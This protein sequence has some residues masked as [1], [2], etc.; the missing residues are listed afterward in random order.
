M[1]KKQNPEQQRTANP[2]APIISKEKIFTEKPQ[3]ISPENSHEN[4]YGYIINNNVIIHYG[5]GAKNKKRN[6]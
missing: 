6:V 4:N 1:N 2:S 3:S 5:N